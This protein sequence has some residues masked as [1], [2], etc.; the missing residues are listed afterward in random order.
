MI[1]HELKSISNTT[2]TSLD[3]ANNIRSSYT[4]IVQ[5]INDTGYIYIGNDQVTSSSYG[6]KI[7]PTQAITIELPSRTTMYA[8]ASASGMSVSVMEIDRAI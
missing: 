5:N 6:F 8:L 4:I 2:A 7:Y 1:R 3:V